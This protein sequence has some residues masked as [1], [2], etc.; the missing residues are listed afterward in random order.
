[1]SGCGQEEQEL[2]LIFSWDL[3]M[4]W[5]FKGATEDTLQSG[6]NQEAVPLYTVPREFQG[7][8]LALTVKTNICAV[9]IKSLLSAL[10]PPLE[11]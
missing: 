7:N 9:L 6:Q 11:N 3:E 10:L 8:M 2:T 4:T 1:M 5:R